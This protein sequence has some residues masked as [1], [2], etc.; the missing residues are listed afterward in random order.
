MC[1]DSVGNIGNAQKP[2][3]HPHGFGHSPLNM[4]VTFDL[5]EIKE[6]M[7]QLAGKQLETEMEMETTS[8][9]FG[10]CLQSVNSCFGQSKPVQS[11]QV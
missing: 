8:H 1:V 2:V 7:H 3:Q 5:S 11:S 9:S 10:G 6:A 4:Y